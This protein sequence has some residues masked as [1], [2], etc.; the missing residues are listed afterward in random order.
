MIFRYYF[1]GIRGK[2]YNQVIWDINIMFLYQKF[3]GGQGD[4]KYGILIF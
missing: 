2:F 1:L 3:I 4:L